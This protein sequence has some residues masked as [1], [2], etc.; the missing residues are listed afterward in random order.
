M[1]QINI[2]AQIDNPDG[3]TDHTIVNIEKGHFEMDNDP[4]DIRLLVKNPVT[5]MFIDAAAKGKLD[6]GKVAQMVK[7]EPGT[8][9]SG[10][11]NADV[12]VKGLVTA[13]EQQK[14]D[15]F[16][17]GGTI[18][19]NQFLYVAKD[20]PTGVKINSLQ[21]EFSPA[22]VAI[23]VLS[24]QY[25]ST[26]FNGTGQINNLLN[27]LLQNKA[28]QANLTVN[29]DNLNLYEW[30]GTAADTAVKGPAAAA[31]V[32]P[33]NLNVMLNSKVGVLHYD[34]MDITNFSGALNIYD[35]KVTLSN[36]KGN[37]LD[38]SIVINGTY[39]TKESKIKPD[40]S[41]NYTVDKVDVQK[42]FQAFNTVQ[43]LMPISKFIAGKLS[44]S[45]TFIGKLGDN[46]MPDL[47]SLTG[48]GNLFLIEGF[49]S[50]FAP[51]DKI[52]STL[53]VKALE[54]ISLKDVKN[55]IE[56]SNGKILV[57]PFTVKVKDIEM[58]IGGLQGFDQSLDYVI[59]MKLPR[60]LMGEQ[61]NKLVDNL[62][63]QINNK[64]IP[65][66]VGET[67]SLNILLGGFF[68][69]PT[70]KT[71]LKQGAVN[72]ADQL[73]QQALDF[74]KTKIDSTKQAITSAVKD[75]I[76][77]VKKQAMDAAKEEIARQLLGDK[78]ANSDSVKPA[79]KPVE[80]IKGLMNNLFK[81]KVKDSVP[82]Q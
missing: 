1:Q 21:T 70:I 48:N 9:L 44:S 15:Q 2:K 55:Y 24:G 42:T 22:K 81:K 50:K 17:A 37:A 47:N 35:E 74:A 64:G 7:L 27:Y 82:H 57:K 16:S 65:V 79:P 10:L 72:L 69:S 61:G 11:L 71:D 18:D 29:A 23:N 34:K 54:Q 76:A 30:M 6:L 49:L 3:I 40:I 52:A 63:T 31:F 59:N 14:Q 28:L 60:S 80:S 45:L 25:L 73:K 46:M 12:F 33:A 58:E 77:S 38:G 32:V 75:S 43:K 4:F 20:Y 62:V 19:L 53:N 78:N 36:V 5:N 8:K 67:V 66:K 51:L 56:F 13:I 39:S 41:M 68:K 26:N